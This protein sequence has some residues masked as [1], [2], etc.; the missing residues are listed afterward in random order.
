MY[1][2]M[3]ID[4]EVLISTYNIQFHDND[5]NKI[6]NI[7]FLE[8]SEE[9]RRDKKKKQ[10]WISHGKR[11]ID[12]RAIEVWLNINIIWRVAMHLV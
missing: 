8:L 7:C 6:L 4:E 9:F 1:N 2:G 10:V 12:V 5:K 3:F 11:A